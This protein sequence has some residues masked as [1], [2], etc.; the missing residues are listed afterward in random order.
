MDA[1][2]INQIFSR[3]ISVLTSL[4]YHYNNFINLSHKIPSDSSFLNPELIF[5][6]RCEV[7]AYI[8]WLGRFNHFIQNMKIKGF[9]SE[10]DYDGFLSD[11]L[12]FRNKWAAHS[13]VDWPEKDDTEDLHWSIVAG[14]DMGFTIINGHYI[15][16]II[17]DDFYK[18]DDESVGFKEYHF[19]L[20][21]EHEFFKN[22]IN[23]IFDKLKTQ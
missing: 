13:S 15:L 5:G 21:N 9:L 3:K 14:L 16:S 19:D 23:T 2:T 18:N 10:S 17:K 7:L 11:V 20:I 6:L 8:I 12:F 22:K 4:D 1:L